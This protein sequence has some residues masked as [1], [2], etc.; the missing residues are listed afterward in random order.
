MTTSAHPAQP[1]QPDQGPP[2]PLPAS[3]PPS[4]GAG[5]ITAL[6]LGIVVLLGS[7]ALGAGGL[8]LAVADNGLRDDDGFLMS[9]DVTLSTAA[10]AISSE[11]LEIHAD[12]AADTV[13]H[14]LLGDAKV[15]A[16]PNGDAPV[17]LGVAATEDADRFLAGVGHSTVAGFENADPVYR[18]TD[19]T[20]PDQAPGDS[21]IWV[22]Q[23]RGRAPRPW[24]GRWRTATGRSW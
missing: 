19:G 16:V 6:V 18:M 11:N 14:A 20:A 1:V 24:C 7:L 3:T 13:P 21:D 10:Y 17:F 12:G 8:V 4:W 5:R 15:T 2:R 23:S 9:P 22:A